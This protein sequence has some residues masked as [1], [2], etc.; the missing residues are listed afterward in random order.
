MAGR[1]FSIALLL[2]LVG[3]LLTDAVSLDLGKSLSPIYVISLGLFFNTCG[4]FADYLELL[5]IT[6]DKIMLFKL[7]DLHFSFIFCQQD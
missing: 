7:R 4:D 2:L 6:L 1:I 3:I 5:G